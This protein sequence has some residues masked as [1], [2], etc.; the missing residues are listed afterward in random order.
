[1]PYFIMNLIQTSVHR[2]HE[3]YFAS[4]IE[5]QWKSIHLLN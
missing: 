3:L 4:S 2:Q 1:M 5:V